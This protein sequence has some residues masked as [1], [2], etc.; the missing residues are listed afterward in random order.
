MQKRTKKCKF[1]YIQKTTVRADLNLS[2]KKTVEPG[3]N[4]FS[5]TTTREN[6]EFAVARS[7][8]SRINILLIFWISV[9]T[10]Q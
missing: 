8:Y 9:S 6:D 7:A 10:V 2:S 1:F 5:G 3:D 4:K